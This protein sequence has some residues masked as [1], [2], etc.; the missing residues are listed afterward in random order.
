VFPYPLEALA[1][2][3]SFAEKH[4][5]R[6]KEAPRRYSDTSYDEL[7]I[8]PNAIKTSLR[9]GIDLKEAL[10]NQTWSGLNISYR[11]SPDNSFSFGHLSLVYIKGD[12][13]EL[14]PKS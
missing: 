11:F 9:L 5:A 4:R 1:S 8:L 13:T 12:K 6:F 14:Q 7:W 10:S 2:S 3:A